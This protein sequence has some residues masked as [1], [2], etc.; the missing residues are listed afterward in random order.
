MDTTTKIDDALIQQVRHSVDIVDVISGYLPLTG[1]GKNFFGVCPFHDDHSPSMSVSKE[2]QIYRCFS[3][4]ASGN[5][6]R[7]I[8]DYEKVSFLEAL[9]MVATKGN[10]PLNISLHQKKEPRNQALYDIYAL[11]HKFYQNNINTMA[12]KEARSY[13]EARHID[14]E[15]IKEFEIGLAL[16]A[17]DL[18]TKLLQKKTYESSLLLKSGLVNRNEY[19]YNDVYYNR[20]MF[21]LWDLSGQVVGFSGRIYNTQDT[22]KYINSK[23][24]EIFKKGELL[25]NYHRAKDLARNNGTIIV[26]EGFMDVIRAYTIGVRNVVAMMGT[27]VTKAQATLLRRMAKEVVLCFDGDPAGAKATFTC[28]NELLA[29][30][31]TPQ[32]VRLEE[33]LDPDDYI[34]KYGKEKFLLKLEHPMNVMDF[35][36]D[37]LKQNRNLSDQIEYSSY[38]HQVID[39]LTKM[40]DPLLKELT[41][42]KLSEESH[43]NVELLKQQLEIKEIKK[44]PVETGKEVIIPKRNKYTKAEQ[45]LLY[46]MLNSIEVI[47]I[48]HNKVAYMPTDRYRLLAKELWYFY[49]KHGFYELADFISTID[50]SVQKTVDEILKLNLKEEYTDEEIK[51]Y[52]LTIREYNMKYECQRIQEKIRQELDPKEKAV[53]LKRMVE[54]RQANE[55]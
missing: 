54:L 20:I 34:L 40:E 21:P 28:A 6:F 4:G 3:C 24:S 53:L 13:L 51:D 41:L 39:E 12:G 27:A 19:G 44:E 16:P 49:Q 50:E 11:S 31:I 1:K 43:L 35:K 17:K 9:K 45:N 47:Q 5:V 25:Y 29:L 36:L 8:M 55:L 2:K 48:Y 18:L 10:I 30:G 26:M 33:N 46:Y 22:S 37:Y 14:K 52:I 38:L 7:F 42:Q 32:I 15:L 23:E